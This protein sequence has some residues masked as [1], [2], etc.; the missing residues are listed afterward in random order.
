MPRRV[1]A[2]SW[3][4]A[5]AAL[6]KLSG[7]EPMIVTTLAMPAIRTPLGLRSARDQPVVEGA[8]AAFLDL[9]LDLPDRSVWLF[10]HGLCGGVVQC[11]SP[12]VT[13][14]A[15]RD[16]VFLQPVH[17]HVHQ[18]LPVLV[19]PILRRGRGGGDATDPGDVALAGVFR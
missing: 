7:D 15:V 1:F 2:A 12:A 11:V 4:A 5:S 19:G 8:V 18:H 14:I 13:P 9:D 10:L 17:V 6:A 16:R 3:T